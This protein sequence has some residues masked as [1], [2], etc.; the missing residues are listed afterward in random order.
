MLELLALRAEACFLEVELE[1]VALPIGPRRGEHLA[2]R[3]PGKPQALPFRVQTDL[4]RAL[5]GTQ[6]FNGSLPAWVV[7]I[8][9]RIS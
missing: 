7:W 3:N 9:V 4:P 5:L 8:G 1:Y 2:A 6:A